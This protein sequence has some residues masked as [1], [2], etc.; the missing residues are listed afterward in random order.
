M[1]LIQDSEAETKGLQAKVILCDAG[2]LEASLGFTRKHEQHFKSWVLWSIPII[3]TTQRLRQE[4][5]SEFKVKSGLHS[6]CQASQ[7]Y[8]MATFYKNKQTPKQRNDPSE[9]NSNK[10]AKK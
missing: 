10:Q 7:H 4:D 8:M 3:S 6:E 1:A 5:C 2:E 9:N